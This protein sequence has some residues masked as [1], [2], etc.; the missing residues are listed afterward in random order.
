MQSGGRLSVLMIECELSAEL[1]MRLLRCGALSA[2]DLHC[3]DARSAALLRHTVLRSC[4]AQPDP[5]TP[6]EAASWR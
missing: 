1:V 6:S 5:D 4:A 2:E 3:L